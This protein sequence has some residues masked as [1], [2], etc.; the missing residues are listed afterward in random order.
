VLYRRHR[1][2]TK[3]LPNVVFLSRRPPEAMGSAGRENYEA[4]L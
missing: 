3:G 1:A 2:V 4:H